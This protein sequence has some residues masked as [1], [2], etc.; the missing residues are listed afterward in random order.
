MFDQGT[1]GEACS[2]SHKRGFFGNM[3][4]VLHPSGLV[5]GD[6]A[7]FW[8]SKLLSDDWSPCRDRRM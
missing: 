6:T 7:N 2:N 5:G 8:G 1:F 3:T 4:T